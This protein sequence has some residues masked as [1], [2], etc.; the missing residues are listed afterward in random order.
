MSNSLSAQMREILTDYARLEHEILATAMLMDPT[1]KAEL[2]RLRRRL[3]EHLGVVGT[4]I[5]RDEQLASD[6]AIQK[7]MSQLFT[8]F[9]Y[10][11]GQH[12]A[13]WPAVRIDDDVERYRESA[14]NSYAKADLFWS[15]CRSSLGFSR[16]DA[17]R[18]ALS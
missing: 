14:E 8:N 10:A 3:A 2:V 12:Q 4:C 9:R 15:W 18:P 13:N 16:E 11:V 17:N 7:Q 5:E 6:P 1:R